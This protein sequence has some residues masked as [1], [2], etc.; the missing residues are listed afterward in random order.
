MANMHVRSV[1]G[2]QPQIVCH[3]TVPN[4]NN[5]VSLN[6]RTALVR[7][8]GVSVSALP[9]G[10]GND[11]TISAAEKTQLANGEKVERTI[12]FALGD[13]WDG[14]TGPQK[15]ARLDAFHAQVVIEVEAELRARLRYFGFTR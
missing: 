5:Q 7:S 14:L 9:D 1:V 4:E 3:V 11:G 8:G 12:P 13:D 10:D 6:L 2:G 15:L